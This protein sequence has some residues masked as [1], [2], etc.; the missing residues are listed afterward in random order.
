MKF[1]HHELHRAGYVRADEDLGFGLTDEKFE[2]FANSPETPGAPPAR[3][4][5]RKAQP[6]PPSE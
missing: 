5:M 4:F 3:Y 2:T 6:L 1:F